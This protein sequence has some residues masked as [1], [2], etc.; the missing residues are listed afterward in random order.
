L[1]M[2]L[3]IVLSIACYKIKEKNFDSKIMEKSGL[4]KNYGNPAV[5]GCGWVVEIDKIDYSPENLPAEFQKDSLDVHLKFQLLD[6]IAN[7][8]FSKN[9]YDKIKIRLIAKSTGLN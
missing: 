7:C 6:E 9:A 3:T 1:L 2:G 5:D 8:G 4:V